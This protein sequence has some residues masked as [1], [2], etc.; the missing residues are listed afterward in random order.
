MA[1]WLDGTNRRAKTP[2]RCG[3]ARCGATRIG[4][5]PK[6]VKQA[7]AGTANTTTYTWDQVD[8]PVDMDPSITWTQLAGVGGDP[9]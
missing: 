9:R 1:S 5:A 2:A 4:F 7:T 8:G 6:D 3:V